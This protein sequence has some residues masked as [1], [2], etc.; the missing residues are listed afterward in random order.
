MNISEVISKLESLNSRIRY[1]DTKVKGFEFNSIIDEV[2][3]LLTS[4]ELSDRNF[5]LN[6]NILKL[7]AYQRGEIKM[8]DKSK[9]GRG[10]QKRLSE[11]KNQVVRE[12]DHIISRLRQHN[13]K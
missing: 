9:E 5:S 4:T 12:I 10:R 6:H 8:F 11:A 1:L 7:E 2:K 3:E 13:F